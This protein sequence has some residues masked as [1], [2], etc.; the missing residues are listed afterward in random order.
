ME[1][2]LGFIEMLGDNDSFIQEHIRRTK[3][4]ET[5]Y[6]YLSQ[7]IQNE[8]TAMLG[9]KMKLMTIKK[10][11]DA[12]YLSVILVCTPDISHKEQNV[13]YCS[14]CGCLRRFNSS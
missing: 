4:G 9:S 2:F 14:M 12:K 7:K 5:H 11:R 10:I 6:H 13:S 1:N 3:G 8:I